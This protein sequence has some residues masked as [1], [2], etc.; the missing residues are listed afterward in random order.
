MYYL[1]NKCKENSL[2]LNTKSTLND[3][4][5][6]LKCKLSEEKIKRK[7]EMNDSFQIQDLVALE[8]QELEFKLGV[9]Y[10]NLKTSQV[11][12]KNIIN[13]N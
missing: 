10:K 11:A 13:E 1:E 4:V 12:L 2:L 3:E 8:K 7:N 9:V 6:Y 5:S